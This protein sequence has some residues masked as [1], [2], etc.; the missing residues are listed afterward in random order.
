MKAALALEYIGATNWDRLRGFEGMMSRAGV[1]ISPEDRVQ[2]G[3]QVAEIRRGDDGLLRPHWLFG[4]RD[5][6]KANSRGT[7]GVYLHYVL[8][9]DRL[10]WV[11]EPVSWRRTARYFAAISI[12]GNVYELSD[13]EAAEWQNVL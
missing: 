8:E 5:Y 10:Y 4:K 3:P 1:H 12:S 2:A 13:E 11:Q 7:R 6:A 9:Q